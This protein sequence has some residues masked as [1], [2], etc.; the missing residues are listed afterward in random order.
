MSSALS[1]DRRDKM[2]RSTEFGAAG[3]MCTR[4][5]HKTRWRGRTQGKGGHDKIQKE[6]VKK[7][8]RREG[9][10]KICRKGNRVSEIG[11]AVKRMRRGEEQVA[12]FLKLPIFLLPFDLRE[13]KKIL[14]VSLLGAQFSS[15]SP[16][17]VG[18]ELA[19]SFYYFSYT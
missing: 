9:K 3:G 1:Y 16:S 2:R 17:L 12:C 18:L 5:Y 13:V 8:R 19:T 14:F 7:S 11:A 6:H 10:T 4:K 15:S